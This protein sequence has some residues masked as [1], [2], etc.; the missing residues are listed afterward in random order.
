MLGI[1][2][3]CKKRV[4]LDGCAHSDHPLCQQVNFT[5]LVYFCVHN[6]TG[7]MLI[8]STTKI[9][10]IC[11][12]NYCYFYMMMKILVFLHTECNYNIKMHS[13]QFGKI[14]ILSHTLCSPKITVAGSRGFSLHQNCPDWLWSTPNSIIFSG[15][16]GSFPGHKTVRVC[17]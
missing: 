16:Q 8:E 9:L 11:Y 12:I 4:N 1:A 13:K 10:A 17:S 2:Q 7:R 6:A 14:G 5:V 3:G 15:H